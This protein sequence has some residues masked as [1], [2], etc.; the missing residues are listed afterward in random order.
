MKLAFQRPQ[1]CGWEICEYATWV[2][3]LSASK[4]EKE[5]DHKGISLCLCFLTHDFHSQMVF[6]RPLS[7]QYNI[8][9]VGIL[10]FG[11]W[12]KTCLQYPSEDSLWSN[13]KLAVVQ[14]ISCALSILKNHFCFF[15]FIFTLHQLS[16]DFL[17]RLYFSFFELLCIHPGMTKRT[18]A[19][20][21]V[22]CGVKSKCAIY[23]LFL[24]K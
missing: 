21:W 10:L 1:S 22:R 20:C 13:N 11:L 7:S 16:L 3:E 6:Y 8:M 23:Q 5:E 9:V 19:L 12:G 17:M 24:F 15:F 18:G 4:W 14:S 2:F